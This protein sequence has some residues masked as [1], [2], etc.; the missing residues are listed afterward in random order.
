MVLS[1]AR[2]FEETALAW[3]GAGGGPGLL[4]EN[5]S[6]GPLYAVTA[7]TAHPDRQQPAQ[8]SGYMLH[9]KFEKV[10]ASGRATPATDL[11]VGD[12]VLVTLD[13]NALRNGRYLAIDCPLPAVLEPLQTFHKNVSADNEGGSEWSDYLEVRADRILF[14]KDEVR[15]GAHRLTYMTR[16]R[17]AGE[18][19]AP[20][21]RA[22]EMYRNERF[23]QT[24]SERIRV[25]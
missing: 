8:Q 5:L 21:A 24:A 14:F 25:R 15:A 13:V 19:V 10:D 1:D 23:A 3:S 20:A 2:P 22:E 12:R 17:A 16:V 11:R 4:I 6:A 9:R 18:A 7:V